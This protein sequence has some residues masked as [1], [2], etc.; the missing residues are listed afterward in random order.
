MNRVLMTKA[1]GVRAEL[2]LAAR[3]L[4]LP[5]ALATACHA[6][7]AAEADGVERPA[8]LVLAL[9]R[10]AD[11]PFQ[12]GGFVAVRDSVWLAT[13]RHD[14]E[15]WQFRVRDGA[16]RARRIWESPNG[17]Q[18]RLVGLAARHSRI[19]LLTSYGNL[20][21]LPDSGAPASPPAPARKVEAPHSRLLALLALRDAVAGVLEERV[22]ITA[23]HHFI[24]SLVFREVDARDTSTVRWAIEKGRYDSEAE[25][26][27]DYTAATVSG[28]SLFIGGAVPPRVW[29]VAAGT[30]PPRVRVE[31]LSGGVAHR[32]SPAERKRVALQLGVKYDGGAVIP[33]GLPTVAH[34]WP[35]PQGFLI[36]AAVG[37]SAS[38]LDLYCRDS[39][40]R[41]VLGGPAIA[42][43]A[44]L[45]RFVVVRRASTATQSQRLQL[46][47]RSSLNAECR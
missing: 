35:V 46:Y 29:T 4:A 45:P 23:P 1:R 11:R 30:T 47:A 28:D 44:V 18:E 15:A 34:V 27:A 9:G 26:V 40:V 21:V 10:R 42:D 2:C 19:V 3:H 41:R 16:I 43:L 25:L 8:D 39:L 36:Q 22:T 5:L 7:R 32:L 6:D 33:A 12:P 20:Y 13:D 14:L 24:D 31:S 38:A 17:S 37:P